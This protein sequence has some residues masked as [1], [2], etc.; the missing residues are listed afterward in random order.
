[1]SSTSQLE[2]GVKPCE[3]CKT[4]EN[5]TRQGACRPTI[6][7]N[8]SVMARL[9]QTTMQRNVYFQAVSSISTNEIVLTGARLPECSVYTKAGRVEA[10]KEGVSRSLEDLAEIGGKVQRTAGYGP[11][12]VQM[13]SRS[14]S[15]RW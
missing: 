2:M 8:A 7:Y 9:L 11:R 3:L 12:H 6:S 10:M 13:L 14:W 15:I 1:M 4:R 5:T